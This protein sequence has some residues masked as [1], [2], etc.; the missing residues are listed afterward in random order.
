MKIQ[1]CLHTKKS[2]SSAGK[3]H[4]NRDKMEN[5]ISFE[6]KYENV[7]KRKYKHQKNLGLIWSCKQGESGKFL[8][9][10]LGYKKYETK[11]DRIT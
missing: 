2:Q 4:A 5:V 11:K 9:G 3:D 8:I 6:K 1:N 7:G 10:S